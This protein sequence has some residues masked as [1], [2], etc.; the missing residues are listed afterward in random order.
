VRPRPVTWLPWLIAALFAL[1]SAVLLWQARKPSPPVAIATSAR[2]QVW[3]PA[4]ATFERKLDN[5]WLAFSPDGTRLA[6][7]ATSA[8]GQSAVWVRDLA[9]LEARMV[10]GTEGA[11]TA[12]WSPD[13]RSIGFVAGSK[14]LRATLQGGAAAPIC[15]LAPR[16]RISATWG[17]AGD[18]LF[19]SILDRSLYR[20]PENGGTPEVVMSADSAR[21]EWRPGAPWFL[22]DGRRFLYLLTRADGRGSIMFAAPGERPRPLLEAVSVAQF[23]EP[24]LLL[25]VDEGRLFARHFDWRAGR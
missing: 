1:P 21:D 13:G 7:V 5:P 16:A 3:P 18:I 22:P 12:F 14:L 19:T 23:T 10:P 15:D 8:A 24:D 6:F 4:G 11:S 25:Y 20:V 17:R 2:F 9:V